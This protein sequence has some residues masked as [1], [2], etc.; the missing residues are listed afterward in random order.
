MGESAAEWVGKVI[1]LRVAFAVVNTCDVVAILW[2]RLP[3]HGSR[4]V[5]RV[6]SPR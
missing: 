5:D 4:I 2:S 6:H 3:Q 1:A